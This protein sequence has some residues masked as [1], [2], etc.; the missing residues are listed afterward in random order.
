MSPDGSLAIPV[1]VISSELTEGGVAVPV[2]G[3]TSAPAGCAVVGQPARRVKVLTSSDLVSG[4]GRYRVDGRPYAMPVYTAPA[5]LPVLGE[6]PLLVYA[7]NEDEWPEVPENRWWE[8]GGVTGCIGAYQPKSAAS[9]AASY[10]NLVSPGVDDLTVGVA[11]NF[12]AATGW[13]FTGTQ[14]LITPFVS[15]TT[16]SAIVQYSDIG[17]GATTR[18]L[19]GVTQPPLPSSSP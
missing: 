13:E 12:S 16:I 7:V 17:G 8:A 19:F 5:D 11:P 2:Y 1:T 9:L 14:Y 10:S 3:Y 4:G 15:T 18:Y 6:A